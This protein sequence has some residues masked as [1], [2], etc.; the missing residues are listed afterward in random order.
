MDELLQTLQQINIQGMHAQQLTDM[1]VGTVSSVDPLEIIKD[2]SQA[3]L[4]SSV[5]HLTEN[6]IEKKIL[7][8]H[9]HEIPGLGYTEDA[10]DN[11]TYYE[12]GESL[13]I[14]NDYAIVNKKLSVGDKVL[15][16][17]V[18]HGQQFIILSRIFG[19]G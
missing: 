18:Q 1:C 8:R 9:Q 10:L 14:E 15:M 2:D 17:S 13:P 12:D 3:P 16:M 11:T 4:K 6:V 7:L 5:L 19:G